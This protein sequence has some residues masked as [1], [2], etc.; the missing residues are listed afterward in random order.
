M[1]REELIQQVMTVLRDSFRSISDQ[2][3][4]NYCA[5]DKIVK[6]IIEPTVKEHERALLRLFNHSSD[7]HHS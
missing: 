6:S 3:L 2:E 7:K 4:R 5:A 1:K